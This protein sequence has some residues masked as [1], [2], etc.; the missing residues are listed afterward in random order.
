MP[1]DV[2]RQ[3]IFKWRE[4]FIETIK[5][6]GW[7]EDQATKVLKAS[8]SAEYLRQIENLN[9]VSDIMQV[10]FKTKYPQKDNVKYLNQQ[11]NI[12]QNNFLRIRNFRNAI[13]DTT[14][15]LSVCLNWNNEMREIKTREAFYYGLSKRTQLEMIHLNI[16]NIDDMYTIIESTEAALLEQMKET[17]D[18]PRKKKTSKNLEKGND[19]KLC[20]YYQTSTHDK[21]N[22]RVLQKKVKSYNIIRTS[23]NHRI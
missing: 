9:T 10:I 11:T 19:K 18:A 21:T 14:Q 15:K 1:E 16:H 4:E 17:S 20:L 13:L 5:L 8:I 3:D 6:A 12:K 7:N 2:Q 23:I 22:C